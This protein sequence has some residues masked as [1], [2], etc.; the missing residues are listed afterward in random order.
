M[1]PADPSRVKPIQVELSWVKPSQAESS[2]VEPNHVEPII[3]WRKHLLSFEC[4]C[5]HLTPFNQLSFDSLVTK[6][7]SRF[8]GWWQFLK[9]RVYIWRE[10][11]L[12]N[13]PHSSSHGVELSLSRFVRTRGQQLLLHLLVKVVHSWVHCTTHWI[14]QESILCEKQYIIQKREK[15]A[16]LFFFG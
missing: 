2:R 9:D 16:M 11:S 15:K 6:S 14:V 8:W 7:W 4:I 3:W 13:Y 10:K 12:I 5:V 1:S